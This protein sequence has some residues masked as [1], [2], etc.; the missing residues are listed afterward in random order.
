MHC[1][2][3]PPTAFQGC[4]AADDKTAAVEGFLHY[5]Y[6]AMVRD[7]IWQYTS[8]DQLQDV[9]MPIER[10]IMNHIFKLAFT[11]TRM[12]IFSE[13]SLDQQCHADSVCLN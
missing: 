9:Q 8:K 7:A 11:P 3:P 10:S 13:V 2:L 1:S 5:L 4:T 6:G 12:G